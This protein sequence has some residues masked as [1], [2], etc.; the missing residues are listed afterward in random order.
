MK[1]TV[2]RVDSSFQIGSGHLMRCLTLAERWQETSEIFFI[3]RDLPGNMTGL[4]EERGYNLLLLPAM[5]KDASLTGYEAWLTV[6]KST[7]ME[8]C[9]RLLAGLRSELL[10]VDH[11]ALDEEWERAVRPLVKEIMVIDDLADRKHDC[12]ILLDQNYSPDFL[13]RYNG[14]VPSGCRLLL[15]PRHVILRREFYEQ[16]PRK[17]D[18]TV[19]NILVF[20]GGS[21]LTDETMK[22]L[23]A[24]EKLKR[25]DIT[26][27]VVVGSSNKNKEA[28]R[29]FCAA[30]KQMNYFCQVSNMA[31]LMQRADLALGAGGTTTWE[32]CYLGLP[33]I[34]IGIADNQNNINLICSQENVIKYLGRQDEVNIDMITDMLLKF[35]EEKDFYLKM[36]N[37]LIEFRRKIKRKV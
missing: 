18:G 7:D 22:A 37:S 21:D 1:K 20:F 6:K 14:L 13:T 32:R 3:S 16:K 23:R 31:E 5:E 11:Y 24:I 10:V 33:A 36:V 29:L 35:I 8:Q 34:V 25:D 2:F 27:N 26:V 9:G 28:V 19:K 12:D 4:I 17:R 15:G 30:R